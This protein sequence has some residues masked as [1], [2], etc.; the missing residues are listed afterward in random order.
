MLTSTPP[1]EEDAVKGT[2]S[3]VVGPLRCF[4]FEPEVNSAGN[5]PLF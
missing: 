1:I 3:E 4:L 2:G 5:V